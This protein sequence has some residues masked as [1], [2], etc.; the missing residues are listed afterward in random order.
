M[1]RINIL[2]FSTLLLIPLLLYI[3]FYSKKHTG[4]VF[5]VAKTGSNYSPGTVNQPWRTIQHA[6][7][8]LTAG[9]TLFIKSGIYYEKVSPENSGSIGNYI[10]Y[11]NF[12]GDSVVINANG[13]NAAIYVDDL[14]Y[15]LFRGI[16]LTGAAGEGFSSGGLY[17]AGESS[18]IIA[19]SII[20]IEN[21]GNGIFL[22]GENN[23]IKDIEIK[24][25]IFSNNRWHGIVL[26]KLVCNALIDNNFIYNNGWRNNWGHG[27]KI[28]DFEDVKGPDGVTITNN[29]ISYSR[30]QGIQ[31][32]Y[33]R[34][35][36]ISGN[37]FHHNGASSIQI[38]D[39]SSTIIVDEN[40]C[41]FNAL[42]YGYETGVWIDDSEDVIVQ[43]NKLIG[44]GIGL[45]IGK[46]NRVI[47]RGNLIFKN[48]G[49]GK[50]QSNA[51]GIIVTEATNTM[52][53]HNTLHHNG[54]SSSWRAGFHT[55]NSVSD[56]VFKNNILSETVNKYDFW[57]DGDPDEINYNNYHNRRKLNFYRQ[58]NSYTWDNYRTK[59]DQD[60]NSHTANPQFID[61]D[62]Q[63]FHLQVNS[64]N[65]NAGCFLT[66]TSSS[67]SGTTINVED[68]RYFTD[69]YGIIGGDSIRIGSNNPVKVSN[70]NYDT[71]TIILEQSISWDKGAGVSYIYSGF[72]PDIGA[73]EYE[74]TSLVNHTN[75]AKE[76][77]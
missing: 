47:A 34:N 1:K 63:D 41:E 9:D 57:V 35:I 20:S 23:T 29:E 54:H 51:S 64:P 65:I 21:E 31:T 74:E 43:N 50:T 71:N 24:N 15:L 69:G 73:S 22:S 61:A 11:L 6:S 72:A 27:I 59:S 53:V 52:I 25:S 62:N 76:R 36:L 8:L 48:D 4:H 77:K 13:K 5:F 16:T 37:H 70:V 17:V 12:P 68:A 60:Y 39:N 55:E 40:I 28:V 46:S 49:S 14:S 2:K 30:T 10:K 56:Y 45:V 67:D 66:T 19:D 38:E 42:E 3:T 26:W 32:W 75:R 33:A 44:N 7:N 58:D 18:N